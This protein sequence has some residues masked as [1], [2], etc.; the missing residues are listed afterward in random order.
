MALKSE[1][2]SIFKRSFENIAELKHYKVEEEEILLGLIDQ[3]A[4]TLFDCDYYTQ[5]CPAYTT[6]QNHQI[7]KALQKERSQAL[8]LQA[9]VVGIHI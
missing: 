5:N 1:Y 6:Y 9:R 2:K 4:E 8:E 3:M 7:K